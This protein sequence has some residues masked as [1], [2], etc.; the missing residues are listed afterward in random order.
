MKSEAMNPGLRRGRG[1][2]VAGKKGIRVDIQQA[3]MYS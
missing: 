3:L 2:R 1:V